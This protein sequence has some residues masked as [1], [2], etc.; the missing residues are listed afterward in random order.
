[1]S[2]TI[3]PRQSQSKRFI[4]DMRTGEIKPVTVGRPKILDYNY[5]YLILVKVA[6]SSDLCCIVCVL[7][8]VTCSYQGFVYV[9]YDTKLT[10]LDGEK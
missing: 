5:K 4:L 2:D 6:V 1:M 10:T 9:I 3:K 7:C 8:Y